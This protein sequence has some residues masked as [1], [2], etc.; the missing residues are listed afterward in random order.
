MIEEGK[1]IDPNEKYAPIDI[2][3]GY[4]CVPSDHLLR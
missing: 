1:D 3:L 2:E 4:W